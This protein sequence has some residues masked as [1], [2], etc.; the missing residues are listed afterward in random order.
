MPKP[1]INRTKPRS[2]LRSVCDF[3][4]LAADD[5]AATEM[6]GADCRV[7]RVAAALLQLHGYFLITDGECRPRSAAGLYDHSFSGF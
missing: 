7:L 4:T 3:W 6:I 2:T 5:V 1:R